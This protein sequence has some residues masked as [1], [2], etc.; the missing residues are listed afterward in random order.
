MI[1]AGIDP[2]L[3]GAIFLLD[4]ETL[5]GRATDMPTHEITRGRKKKRDLDPRQL[6]AE[7]SGQ[8]IEHAFIEDVYA[9]P[10]QGVS[11]VFAFGQCKGALI[12]ILAALDIPITRVPPRIWKTALQVPAAKDGARARASQLL[13][14][15]ARH[16]PLVKHHGR[17][18]AAL[19]ALYGTRIITVRPL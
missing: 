17:A 3:S 18:E 13:P 16:W 9:M 15:C 7:L 5:T 6:V 11:G 8:G 2:G 10:G 1:L 4:V 14:R 12:G 19:L